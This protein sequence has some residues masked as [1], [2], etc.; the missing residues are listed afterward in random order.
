MSLKSDS[1]FTLIETVIGLAIMAI[2]VMGI[3]QLFVTNLTTV[4]L[5][6][7]RAVGLAA[8]NQQ[9]EYLRTLAY[10]DVSVAGGVVFPQGTIPKNQDVVVDSMTLTVN[11]DIRYVDDPY[12]G[13]AGGTPN[14]LNPADYKRAQVTVYLKSSGK[15]LAQLTTDIAA[16]TESSMANSGVLSVNVIDASGLPVEGATVQVT[17]TTTS[18]TVNLSSTTDSSGILA[19]PNLPIDSSNDYNVVVTK[20]G[21]STEQTIAEPA[22]TQT[23][24]RLNPNV[25]LQ[26][27]TSLYLPIDKLSNLTVNVKDPTGAV[28]ANSAITITGA[29]KT[30]LTPDVYKYSQVSTTDATGTIALTGIEWDSYSFT[31]PTGFYLVTASPYAPLALSPGVSQTINLVLSATS[32]L[33]RIVKV[34]PAT[35]SVAAGTVAVTITGANMPSGTTVKLKKAGS[36]DI[37]ATSVVST[38][39]GATLT[40]NFS[41]T[42]ASAGTW[43]IAVTSTGTTTQPGGFIVTP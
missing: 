15:Q 5:G 9:M 20:A 43:D 26:Q 23:A 31:P 13:K 1:G 7:A 27:V 37:S 16:K 19:I 21:Y 14:D 38:N 40:M 17:N 33:P 12:D 8:A 39:G 32:T 22:G 30:K 4:A 3:S 34:A 42:G 10:T 29:K 36:T 18:P 11:T 25:L 6:K 24:Y 41:L 2:M 35:G 28:L